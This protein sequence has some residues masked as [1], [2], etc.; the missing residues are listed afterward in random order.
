MTTDAIGG[1]LQLELPRAPGEH[2]GDA[3]RFQSARA[4]FLALISACRPDAVWLP[5]Y[6]CDGML[7]PLETAGIPVKR[8]ALDERLRAADTAL[9][10]REWLVYVNYFGVCRHQVDDV[11]R[12]FPRERVV[13]DNAQAFFEPP[14]DCAATL[15]SPRKFVGVPD[16]G[17][18]VSRHAIPAPAE[19]DR[20][21]PRRFMH[22]LKRTDT[23]AESG[24]SDYARAEASLSRQPPRRMST[25]TQRLLASVDYAQIRVRRLENFARLHERIGA[26]NH[27]P[28]AQEGIGVP[29]CYPFLG[30]PDGARA[31]LAAERVYT[32]GYWPEVAARKIV[33]AW[34]AGLAREA[35]FLPCD[36]RMSEGDVA[37]V[38]D[39]VAAVCGRERTSPVDTSRRS[40]PK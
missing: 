14:S 31:R 35:L 15:Y 27:F 18:L 29:L 6:I 12:R 10:P 34:E 40:L 4:A 23:G 2:H 37:R 21:S 24:Y 3:L 20:D 19:I 7:E 32:P 38:A 39:L 36:Q 22:L 11:L 33:P 8:Y 5:H 26:L 16:G 25:L 1:Y 9:G 30:A 28:F 17:Y 13:I